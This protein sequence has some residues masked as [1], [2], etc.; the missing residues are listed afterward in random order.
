MVSVR[1]RSTKTEGFNSSSVLHLKDH[2]CAIHDRF[3]LILSHTACRHSLHLSRMHCRVLFLVIVLALRGYVSALY[4]S[5]PQIVVTV[6]GTDSASCGSLA[7]PCRTVNH[8]ARIAAPHTVINV[9][10]GTYQCGVHVTVPV[11]IVALDSGVTFN[12]RGVSR[13]V[14]FDGVP[15]QVEGIHF[16][17]GYG[18]G[19]GC[20]LS[21]QHTESPTTA[22]SISKCTFTGC[23]AI[24]SPSFNGVGGAVLIAYS[25]VRSPRTY[26]IVRSTFESNYAR[27]DSRAGGAV[28]V[29]AIDADRGLSVARSPTQAKGVRQCQHV[30]FDHSDSEDPKLARY[31]DA[32]HALGPRHMIQGFESY[33]SL[34]RWPTSEDR[35]VRWLAYCTE[36][37]VYGFKTIRGV[38]TGRVDG[39]NCD[40][41][42]LSSTEHLFVSEYEYWSVRDGARAMLAANCQDAAMGVKCKSFHAVNFPVAQDGRQ[43][44][45]TQIPDIKIASRPAFVARDGSVSQFV[46]YCAPISELI[47]TDLDP[48]DEANTNGSECLRGVTSAPTHA[49]H[50]VA[51]ESWKYWNNVTN[52]WANVASKRTGGI[53]L[54]CVGYRSPPCGVVELT[55]MPTT[56][57]TTFLPMRDVTRREIQTFEDRAVYKSTSRP[58]RFMSYCQKFNEWMVGDENPVLNPAAA[59]N[60]ERILS[61]LRTFAPTPEEAGSWAIGRGAE[62]ELSTVDVVCV[63]NCRR[64]TLSTTGSAL[65]DCAWCGLYD[66]A[67]AHN[68]VPYF[69]QVE[70]PHYVIFRAESSR[71]VV[72]PVATLA[73]ESFA[74]DRAVLFS[75][76]AVAEVMLVKSWE[77]SP[78]MSAR[79]PEHESDS[80]VHVLSCAAVH[81][82]SGVTVH[83]DEYPLLTGDFFRTA[84]VVN[85]RPTYATQDG[86]LLE[87]SLDARAWIIRHQH[88]HVALWTSPTVST[89]PTSGARWDRK[90]A[91]GEVT[92]LQVRANVRCAG[93]EPARLLPGATGRSSGD[94][95]ADSSFTG[96]MALGEAHDLQPTGGA[97]MI[98]FGDVTYGSYTRGIVRNIT[99]RGNEGTAPFGPSAADAAGVLSISSIRPL[100]HAVQIVDSQFTGNQG[101]QGGAIGLDGVVCTAVRIALRNNRAT[102]SGGGVAGYNSHI[103]MSQSA[104]SHNNARMTGGCVHMGTAS[105]LAIK[106][107]DLINNTA[108]F[109]GGVVSSRGYLYVVGSNLYCALGRAM[110]FVN[111]FGC[112]HDPAPTLPSGTRSPVV[113]IDENEAWWIWVA[114]GS[115][116]LAQS[117]LSITMVVFALQ[118][119]MAQHLSNIMPT[120]RQLQA[121]RW[122]ATQRQQQQQEAAAQQSTRKR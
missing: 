117:M 40:V 73:S 16:I 94:T 110:T 44:L 24:S 100:S 75:R 42:G 50:P 84:R 2:A 111:G 33:N 35:E 65:R 51:V 47:F 23:T 10:N 57:A 71:W 89:V 14:W 106:N 18:E 26:T 120:T 52:S 96:N 9:G 114:N 36:T 93:H 19:A 5:L 64:F 88:S 101:D 76:R 63:A 102:V 109:S 67:G 4:P 105:R 66:V 38:P 85:H 56:R 20:V 86:A 79:M 53:T 77:P 87:Y 59:R 62:W 58:P 72:S 80:T 55:N 29:R 98:H 3:E 122:K 83:H 37:N 107:S 119:C 41:C 39:C 103:N 45:F 25:K 95:I 48:R 104:C 30:S 34:G 31:M 12:C 32:Y 92:K 69:R 21:Q 97:V 27:G 6:D 54:T 15:A 115:S 7:T 116:L 28:A 43:G 99:A 112:A 90:A 78:A 1:I 11:S 61:S 118:F 8:A 22:S 108:S 121:S 60:C 91:D 13:G 70:A 74:V 81:N 49:V 68:E 46:W 82:C 113:P 17:D